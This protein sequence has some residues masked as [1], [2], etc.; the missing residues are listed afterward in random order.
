MNASDPHASGT[1][2]AL[3][4]YPVKSMQGEELNSGQVGECGLLGDRAY[5]LVD[6]QDGKI[7][8]AKTRAN[9]R[10]SSPSGPATPSRPVPGPKSLQC[11][12]PCRMGS[13]STARKPTSRPS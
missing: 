6:A 12:S 7:A 11:E 2:V 3:W 8:S 9:G 1:I 5:A 4:R 10:T 13:L